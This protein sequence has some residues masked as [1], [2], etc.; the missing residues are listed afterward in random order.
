MTEPAPLTPGLSHV[1]VLVIKRLC[2]VGAALPQAQD[3]IFCCHFEID[4]GGR[5]D[6]PSDVRRPRR[7]D[8]WEWGIRVL[9]DATPILVKGEVDALEHLAEAQGC[10]S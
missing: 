9:A 5:R 10:L 6:A 7:L 8:R 1:A 2:S 4:R 3:D